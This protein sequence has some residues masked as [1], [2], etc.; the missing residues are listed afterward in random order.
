MKRIS[1]L[2]VDD[3]SD[4]RDSIRRLLQFEDDIEVVGESGSGSEAIMFTEEHRPDIILMDIN[5]PEMDGIRATELLAQR[6]P[7][8]SVIIMSV[9]GEHAYLRRAMMAG[10]REYIVKP[11]SGDEL[12]SVIAKVYEMDRQK[13][14]AMG[15]QPKVCVEPKVRNGEIISFFSTKGGVG[16]TTLATNL[17][18]QLASTGK[19]RVLLIDLNL[20]FGNVAVFLN[21]VPKRSI[22]DLIESGPL[23]FSEIQSHFLTHSS[24]LQVLAAPTRPEYAELV[25]AMHV[26]QILREVKAHFD[27]IICDNVSRFEDVSLVTFDAA[28]QIWLVVAM[29]VP[30]LK[31]AKLSLEVIEGLHHTPKVQVVLNRTSKEMGMDPRDVEKSLNFKISYEIPSDGRALVAALN[32]GV[33]FV[34]SYP[35]SKAS[36]AIRTMAG[37]LISAGVVETKLAVKEQRT[38]QS[39]SKGIRRVF[40]F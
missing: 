24:G 10:A 11:F 39:P 16:K 19:W 28:T 3:I 15:E 23:E 29:D 20:Q 34:T 12:A 18:V 35:Q 8:S 2:I 37:K 4:T 32:Q 26:E 14:E 13:K 38:N 17:A 6:A 5:M 40:G 33:P 36:E 27:F 9:Q 7:G 21:L 31:N 25:T 22:A 1:V 30:T